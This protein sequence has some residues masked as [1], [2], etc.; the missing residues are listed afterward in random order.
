MSELALMVKGRRKEKVNSQPR[1]PISEVAS[2]EVSVTHSMTKQS[3]LI[4]YS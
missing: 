1:S 3:Q 4:L 2:L